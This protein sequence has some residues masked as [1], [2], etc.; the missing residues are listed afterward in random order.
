MRESFANTRMFMVMSFLMSLSLFVARIEILTLFDQISQE[1]GSHFYVRPIRIAIPRHLIGQSPKNG[2]AIFQSMI[3]LR[4]ASQVK[5]RHI[6][7][8]TPRAHLRPRE[9]P[10]DRNEEIS[11]RRFTVP[12]EFARLKFMKYGGKRRPNRMTKQKCPFTWTCA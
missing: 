4:T 8:A 7:H 2:M 11:R 1:H 9:R 12:G 3:I 10:N 5:S 6:C